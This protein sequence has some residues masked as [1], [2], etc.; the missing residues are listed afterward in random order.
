MGVPKKLANLL[1]NIDDKDSV[2]VLTPHGRLPGALEFH[3]CRGNGQGDV[4]SPNKW[5]M[6]A[7]IGLTAL[8]TVAGDL[9]IRGKDGVLTLARDTAFCDDEESYA[10]TLE[11]MQQKADIKSAVALVLR[12][13]LAINKFRFHSLKFTRRY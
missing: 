13:P 9:Y 12:L 11:S 10:A 2:K 3:T 6:L 7:D 8:A 5:T 4:L 1:A